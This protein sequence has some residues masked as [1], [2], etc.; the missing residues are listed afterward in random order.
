MRGPGAPPA[1]EWLLAN[2]LGGG[3]GG[4]VA[5][6]PADPARGL[7]VAGAGPRALVPLL[8]LEERVA[9]AGG[10]F[11]LEADAPGGAPADGHA[12][13]E[14][15]APEPWPTWRWRAGDTVLERVVLVPSGHDAVA[16][17]YRHVA[18]PAAHVAASPLCAARG[19][20]DAPGTA[21]PPLASLRGIPGRVRIEVAGAGR[22]LTLWHDGAFLPA[23]AWRTLA[24]AGAA[25]PRE[26]ALVPG[27]AEGLV[28]PGRAFHLVFAVE[29]DLFRALAAAGRLGEPPA[30]TL[31]GCVAAIEQ[32]ERGHRGRWR[33]AAVRGA[34]FTARQ[35]AT[36]HGGDAA[37]AA[38]G[39]AP[40]V[41]GDDAALAGL[42]L[43]V[44]AG[45]V[46]RGHRRTLLDPPGGIERGAE[47]LRAVAALVSLRAFGLAREILAG[48]VEYLD[49]GLAPEAFDA[50][51][52]GPRYGDP[53]PSLWLVAA[54]DLYARR[55][56]DGEFLAATLYPALDAVTSALRQGTRH[57]VRV[58]PDGLLAVGDVRRADLNA[59]WQHALVAMAQLARRLGHRETAA[60][61]LAWAH[62]HRQR[63]LAAFWDEP[64]G[65]LHEA[66][67]PDG[68]V[69]GLSPSQALA[70]GL[71]PS[72]L[73]P[74]PAARLVATLERELVT[75]WGLRESPGAETVSTAALGFFVPA[76]LR[77]RGRD[78]AA[79]ARARGW[80]EAAWRAGPV[81]GHVPARLRVSA[82]AGGPARAG[83]PAGAGTPEPEGP[84]ASTLAAAE[85]LRLRIEELAPLPADA[86]AARDSAAAAEG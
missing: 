85:L 4:P 67:T 58:G 21:A 30:R 13:L 65:R 57:G 15:F 72:L 9:G 43:A 7:L 10:A 29:E 38:R 73:E 55:S 8:A 46:R 71:P 37:D 23:R 69:A 70:A 78:G 49:E 83:G 12:R 79:Q 41:D 5:G 68:P 39:D 26:G 62:E 64:R 60:F 19:L 3:A 52:G 25:A 11:R 28:A 42:A 47:A 32:D 48:Y 56:A 17:V 66:L 81:S 2:G 18:G 61:H 63:F 1:A 80:V 74:E 34:D 22:A 33:R 36:A 76:W 40:L 16:V 86:R 6:P 27:H 44:R 50:P 54:A 14:S 45:L 24:Y 51:D 20:D 82:G 53:A 59:L 84:P 75:P 31:A 35:A 77:A